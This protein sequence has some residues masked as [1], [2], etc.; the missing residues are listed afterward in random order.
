MWVIAKWAFHAVH[1]CLP[2]LAR[3]SVRKGKR[4]DWELPGNLLFR[5]SKFYGEASSW[6]LRSVADSP[7]RSEHHFQ[8]DEDWRKSDIMT[9]NVILW[10]CDAWL[11]CLEVTF[12]GSHSV[13]VICSNSRAV[14]VSYKFG[15]CTLDQRITIIIRPAALLVFEKIARRCCRDWRCRVEP[16]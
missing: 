6:Y 5:D 2:A 4:Q 12:L 9:W 15:R 11:G 1:E 13:T 16:Y 10:P 3:S 8:F 7:V 14:A